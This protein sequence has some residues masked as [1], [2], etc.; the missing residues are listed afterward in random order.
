MINE[1]ISNNIVISENLWKRDLKIPS[2]LSVIS[3]KMS[4]LVCYAV[5]LYSLSNSK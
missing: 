3:R 5:A 1:S 2:D 4:I